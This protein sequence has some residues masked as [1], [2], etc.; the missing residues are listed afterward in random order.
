MGKTDRTTA[1]WDSGHSMAAA[2]AGGEAGM[3]G[4]PRPSL[5]RR[6]ASPELQPGTLLAGRF[7]VVEQLGAGSNGVAY[8]CTDR[9]SGRQ[10]AV[11]VLS[12]RSLRDWKQ[13]ELFEREAQVLKRWDTHP[14]S[15]PLVG[16]GRGRVREEGASVAGPGRI[17]TPAESC[18]CAVLQPRPPRH[19]PLPRVV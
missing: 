17:S 1:G 19:P 18:F 14:S 13:L 4:G 8:R 12:L 15:L 2:A 9:A 11:K 10:V 7:E 5:P 16:G 6:S 3:P